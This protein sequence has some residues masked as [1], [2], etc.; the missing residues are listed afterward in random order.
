M[1]RSWMPLKQKQM[2]NP[3]QMLLTENVVK[4]NQVKESLPKT[5][6]NTSKLKKA[7]KQI[8]S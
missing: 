7:K 8:L 5:L 3:V 4:V 2:V 6:T 1:V